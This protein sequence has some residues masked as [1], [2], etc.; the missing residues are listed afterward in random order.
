MESVILSRLLIKRKLQVLLKNDRNK[1]EKHST[2]SWPS[3]I[4]N[5]EDL[6]GAWIGFWSRTKGFKNT[7]YQ[8]LIRALWRL[9]TGA[10]R[11]LINLHKTCL[12]VLC[13]RA[14]NKVKQPVTSPFSCKHQPERFPHLFICPGC[15]EGD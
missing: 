13:F 6:A 10:P 5:R 14:V 3:T 4:I 2:L 15:P 1:E 7:E 12:L 11:L 8:Q 9:P